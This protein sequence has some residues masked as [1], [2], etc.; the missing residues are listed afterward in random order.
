MRTIRNIIRVD[1]SDLGLEL[2]IQ[3]GSWLLAE[4]IVFAVVHLAS[5]VNRVP[6]AGTAAVVYGAAFCMAITNT[7]RFIVEYRM[8]LC[9][10]LS[11]RGVL[12]GHLAAMLAH[13]AVLAAGALVWAGAGAVLHPLLYAGTGLPCVPTFAYTPWF[14]WLILLLAPQLVAVLFGGII[15]RF[16]RVGGWALYGVLV[17]CCMT[18]DDIIRFFEGLAA[19][20]NWWLL[21]LGAA[22]ALAVLLAL[23]V[24]WL[25]RAPVQS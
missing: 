15:V 6:S 12:L 10:P 17:V 23:C 8:H 16:G 11:R 1:I 4:I 25:L 5:D 22:L 20:P 9:F 18:L 3:A 7:V 13:N 24:R 21:L 19:L 2:G 14:A